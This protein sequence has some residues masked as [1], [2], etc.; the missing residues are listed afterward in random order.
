V[1]PEDVTEGDVDPPECTVS[2]CGE[3]RKLCCGPEE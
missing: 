3:G 2:H 1:G